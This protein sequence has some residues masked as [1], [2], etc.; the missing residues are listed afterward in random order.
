MSVE[1]IGEEVGHVLL[2]ESDHSVLLPPYRTH[3]RADAF[4]RVLTASAVQ[5]PSDWLVA[6][7]TKAA[8]IVHQAEEMQANRR[9][10]G[11]RS[12]IERNPRKRKN[13][14]EPDA[15]KSFKR[16][17][18][19]C[20]PNRLPAIQTNLKN[21]AAKKPRRKCNLLVPLVVELGVEQAVKHLA[22]ARSSFPA[23]SR[24][25]PPRPPVGS[26]RS[27]TNTRSRQWRVK[28]WGAGGGGELRG[29]RGDGWG[30]RSGGRWWADCGARQGGTTQRT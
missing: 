28:A 10:S 30:R 16:P 17:K 14:S 15:R 5:E 12:H 26:S 19:P 20:R 1:A 11:T 8:F 2:Q 29:A 25:P 3:P 23:Q 22:L 4:G 6:S 21:S 18:N 13:Q 7:I 27:P 9:E 24:L